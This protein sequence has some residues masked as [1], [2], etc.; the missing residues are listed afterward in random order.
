M[1]LEVLVSKIH[2]A[3]AYVFQTITCLIKTNEGLIKAC[4]KCKS[5]PDLL[6]MD[7]KASVQELKILSEINLDGV[8]IVYHIENSMLNFID[9]ISFIILYL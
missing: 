4:K 3:L 7:N 5:R 1:I 6:S 2:I 8:R 9:S